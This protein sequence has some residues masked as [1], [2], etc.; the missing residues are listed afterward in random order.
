[1]A[2]EGRASRKAC[3]NWSGRFCR[4]RAGAGPGPINSSPS[5]S[6][7]CSTT[8]GAA[9]APFPCSCSRSAS[10]SAVALVRV[11]LAVES[12][13]VAMSNSSPLCT[14][15]LG[16]WGDCVFACLGLRQG[17]VILLTKE[18]LRGL[19]AKRHDFLFVLEHNLNFPSAACPYS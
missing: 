10:A 6:S 1:M 3:S 12:L 4:C 8:A 13:V 15:V 2:A 9:A 7:C 11:E 18:I 14:R 19:L 16:I 5:S 17:R